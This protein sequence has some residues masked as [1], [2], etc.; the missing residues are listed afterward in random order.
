MRLRLCITVWPVILAALWLTACGGGQ[1]AEEP[2][3]ATAPPASVEEPPESVTPPA[4]PEAG[5]PRFKVGLLL[6]L[7]GPD[8]DL[9]Q[10]FLRAAQMALFDVGNPALELLPRDVGTT[11]ESARQAAQEALNDGAQILLGPIFRQSVTAAGAVARKAGVPLIGF[12]N[13]RTVAGNGVFL[14]GL[15]PQQEVRRIIQYAA[16]RNLSR[17]AA[18]IPETSYGDAVAAA[19]RRSVQTV[20]G[21]LVRTVTYPPEREALF[22]PVKRLAD[23]DRRRQALKQEIA[24]LRSMGEGDSLAQLRLDDLKARDTL[25]RLPFDALLIPEG[26]ALLR[27]LVPL[28]P[29]YDIDPDAVQFLGTGLW[30]DPSLR[31][32]PPLIGGWFAAPPRAGRRDFENRYR[33][34]YGAAPPR[35]ATLVYDAMA[36]SATLGLPR[37]EDL[38]GRTLPRNLLLN[39]NGFQGLNGIFRFTAEGMAE[40]GLAVMEITEDGI[41]VI[42]PAPQSFQALGS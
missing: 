25:G 23:Y 34:I 37:L 39:P 17:F 5:E 3:V 9:G 14:T 11:P 32:E 26:G 15:A 2:P 22:A 41:E 10:A 6:P 33:D 28:L 40:R 1:P 16:G 13:D 30:D 8:R 36:L 42:S 4:K 24:D 35:L 29:Y 12:S 38:R 20:N 7:T 27:A 31:Q 18:L 21:D 19:F